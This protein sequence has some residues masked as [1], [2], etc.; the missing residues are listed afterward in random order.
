M[1]ADAEPVS[2]SRRNSDNGSPGS[3]LRR[4]PADVIEHLK[5]CVLDSIGCG[6]YG[7]VQP[8]GRIAGDVAVSFSGGGVRRCSPA[9]DKVSP[10]DAALANG[11]A[12]HGFEIDDAHVSSSL[13]PGAVT[14]PAGLAVGRGARRI[15]QRYADGAGGRL[16]S[17]PSRRHLRRRVAFD[18]RLPRHRHGRHARRRRGGGAAAAICRRSR[19][20]TR[21]GSARHRPRA[22][23]P[24]AP[25]P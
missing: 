22:S 9:T 6:L 15:G 16:R 10:A 11:T 24:R 21:L 17:R 19:P 2:P 8:W 23:M 18:Q 1:D 14:L 25:A 13:H 12:I 7:A 3:I 5:L 4:I 20:R